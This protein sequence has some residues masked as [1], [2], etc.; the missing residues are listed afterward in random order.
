MLCGAEKVSL[1]ADTFLV[2][3]AWEVQK[4]KMKRRENILE[5]RHII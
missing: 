5:A 4:L 2:G 3:F 1:S